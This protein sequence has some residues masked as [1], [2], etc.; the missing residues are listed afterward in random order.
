VSGLTADQYTLS[1]RNSIVSAQH[2]ALLVPYVTHFTAVSDLSPYVTIT[3]KDTRYDRNTNTIAYDV[4][5]KNTSQFSLFA[6]LIL[7]LDP[8]QGFNG[9]PQSANPS[10]GSWLLSL[11]STVPGGVALKPG[12]TTSGATVVINNPNNLEVAYTSQ[13]TGTPPS[14]SAPVFD[15]VPITTV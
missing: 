11:T 2:V 5:V 7:I 13:V 10:G 1:V 9:I 14:A 4:T 12:D 6:P 15:S 8:S 3:Y